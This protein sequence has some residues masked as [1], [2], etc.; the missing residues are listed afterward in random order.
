MV[1]GMF[2]GCGTAKRG[3]RVVILRKNSD[4]KSIL[5]TSIGCAAS[6]LTQEGYTIV[7][8]G[9]GPSP[10]RYSCGHMS[11]S[12]F[13]RDQYMHASYQTSNRKKSMEQIAHNYMEDH[14]AVA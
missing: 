9:P 13:T 14:N 1:R 7:A 5:S 2:A 6:A 10:K 12:L 4:K 8:R 3:V 11:F